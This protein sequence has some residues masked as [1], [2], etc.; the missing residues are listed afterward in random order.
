MIKLLNYDYPEDILIST[1]KA[2]SVRELCEVVFKEL[3]LNYKD[4]IVINKRF[5]RPQELPYLQGDSR[6][7]RKMLNWEPE[8]T[9]RTL[10]LDMMKHFEKD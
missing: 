5:F 4:H 7:G 2:H 3:G 6:K 10:L 8:F 9:F 1:G